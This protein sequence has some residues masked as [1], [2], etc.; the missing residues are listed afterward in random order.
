MRKTTKIQMVGEFCPAGGKTLVAA[1]GDGKR[2]SRRRRLFRRQPEGQ[3]H[4][5]V[6][7]LLPV[8]IKPLAG[9]RA[10]QKMQLPPAEKTIGKGI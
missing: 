2:V 6:S 10:G 3:K 8:E 9:E 4:P 7:S 5:A 1:G